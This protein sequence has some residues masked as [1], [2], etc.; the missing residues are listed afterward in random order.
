MLRGGFGSPI[1][2]HKA[3]ELG[4][5]TKVGGAGVP[6]LE[7]AVEEEVVPDDDDDDDK[8]DDDDVSKDKLVKKPK[9][10]AAGKGKGKAKPK[11]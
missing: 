6:D 10:A 5:K 7:D 9:A 1:A 3:T 2:F 11:K 4:V 8:R